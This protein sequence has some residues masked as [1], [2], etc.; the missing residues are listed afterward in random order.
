VETVKCY[1]SIVLQELQAYNL[2]VSQFFSVKE[3]Y[4]QV[5]IQQQQ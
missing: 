4:G 1:P 5:H 3:V 2:S